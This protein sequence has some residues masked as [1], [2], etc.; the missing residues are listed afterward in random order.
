MN[1]SSFV[2][3][4]ALCLSF[5]SAAQADPVPTLSSP[6]QGNILTRTVVSPFGVDWNNTYWCGLIKKHTGLDVQAS[7]G[8]SIYAA[9]DGFVRVAK[10]D[11]EW[12]G[13][14]SLDH[15][16]AHTFNLVTTYWHITPSVSAGTWVTKGQKV[17]TVVYLATGT[18]FH[19]STYEAAY[20]SPAAFAGSLPQTTCSGY[21]AF[22][23][24]FKSPTSYSYTNK[25]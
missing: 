7:V 2:A 24:Y 1:R 18:H 21:P 20:S 14:V 8:E 15:G 16:P 25:S 17:G 5:V 13:Y 19:F 4:V 9:Y 10:L 3:K 23:S 22:P 6:V 12:G 11:A